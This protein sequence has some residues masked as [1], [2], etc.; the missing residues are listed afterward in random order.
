[1]DIP[2]T[3]TDGCGMMLDTISKKNM[4]VR[5]P[6][7]KGLLGVFP[8]RKFIELANKNDSS[9][10][11]AIVKDIYNKNHD[12]IK[13]DIQIIFTKSQFKMYKYYEN[14]NEYV[15]YFK[16]YHCQAGYCNLEEDNIKNAKINY[17]MIQTLN[18]MTD[19]ELFALTKMSTKKIEYIST[20]V[21]S[22]LEVFGVTK[23]NTNKTDLQQAL[24]I[25]PE[26]LNDVYTKDVL[27]GI[28]Q[29]LVKNYKA[30]KLDIRGKYT[31][32]LPD[33]YAFSEHLFL[34]EEK[35]Q[36]LLANGEVSC[37]IYKNVNRLDCLRSPHLYREHAVRNNVVSPIISDWFT[38]DA[39]YTSCFDLI[40]KILQ[41]DVDGDKS[42][43]V[44]DRNLVTVADRH[45]RDIVP[46]YYDMQKAAPVQLDGKTI[47]G[48]LNAAYTGGN[49]GAISNDITKIWNSGDT[50]E[51]AM[52]A[53]KFLC[54]ENNFTIDYAKTLYKPTRPDEINELIK[55]Y[56][57]A[58]VPYFFMYAK[59]KTENQV[60]PINESV[61]NKLDNIIKDKRLKF[62]LKEFGKLDYILLMN[63]SDIEIDNDLLQEYIKMNGKY[64]YKINMEDCEADNK[65]VIAE[66]IR[67]NLAKYKYSDV[68]ITDMLVKYLYGIKHS[69]SKESLWFCYGK[70]I[71]E[72]LKRNIDKKT[73]ICQQCGKRFEKKTNNQIYCEDCAYEIE[74]DNYEPIG[75]KFITCIDCGK[76]IEVDAKANNRQR[77]DE[78]ILLAKRKFKREWKQRNK[79]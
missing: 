6:W 3:H 32:L 39:V 29:S 68:D 4:M 51:D 61:V 15:K 49:I 62:S 14:W 38:T 11:H 54:M 48:G 53:I 30:A 21:R 20:T 66:D 34:G 46:L 75:T 72:N 7:V 73:S 57:K 71:V 50:N 55:R 10:N 47:Y 26:L 65:K 33:L 35:P 8:F 70:V 17:Q 63:N 41:F 28:K 24:E 16:G 42:L 78:C 56:T 44:S 58:K 59:D 52:K 23:Y 31:F 60:E 76:E 43:V 79:K 37:R 22:M 12:I 9:I 67:N 36:G 45:M 64:H 74:Y 77:C 18:Y 5:L 69:K 25:Y 13:E 2:I 40:S 1:M 19:A 27:R